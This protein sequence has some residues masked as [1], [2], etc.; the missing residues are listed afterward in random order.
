M[1]RERLTAGLVILATLVGS[2]TLFSAREVALTGAIGL[3]L[4][5]SWIHSAIARNLAEGKNYRFVEGEPSLPCST[6]P[7]WTALEAAGMWLARPALPHQASAGTRAIV[8]AKALG[9]AAGFAACLVLAFLAHRVT[10][11]KS[12]GLLAGV[13]LASQARFVW[14]VLSGLEVPLYVLLTLLGLAAH[15]AW[16]DSAGSRRHVPMALFALALLTTI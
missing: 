6:A 13:L 9:F 2:C 8:V 5:D 14:G 15:L 7:L 4:D 12:L 11:S 3:P 16:R 1:R 10:G